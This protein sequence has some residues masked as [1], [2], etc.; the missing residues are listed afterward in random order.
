MALD[1][2]L[3]AALLSAVFL[4]LYLNL[5]F[6]LALIFKD[7]S[8]MDYAWGT[9]FILVAIVSLLAGEVADDLNLRSLIV[10]ALVTLWGLRLALYIF[11]RH[12]GKG[13]DWRYKKWREDW[14]KWFVP[15][16]YL[17]VF[18]LQGILLMIIAAPIIVV[19]SVSDSDLTAVDLLGVLVWLIGFFFEAAGDWQLSQFK[20][21]PNNKGKIMTTGLWKYTRHPNYFGEVTMWWGIFLMALLVEFPLGLASIIGPAVITFLILRVSG[22][23]MLEAKYKGNPDFEAYAQRTS[24]FFPWFPKKE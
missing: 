17:Q 19:N 24:A 22:I 13:E 18:M 7:N 9:G 16:S 4:F 6:I 11:L 2:V 12:R 1:V 14:G 20:K 23:T 5:W 8:I 21:D 3:E 15:R 10:T